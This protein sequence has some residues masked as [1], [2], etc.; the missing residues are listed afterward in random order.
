MVTP[1]SS[2]LVGSL[3][4]AADEEALGDGGGGGAPGRLPVAPIPTALQNLSLNNVSIWHSPKITTNLLLTPRHRHLPP[5]SMRD[6][7]PKSS[8]A[9]PC[10]RD[11]ASPFSSFVV[12]IPKPLPWVPLG[13]LDVSPPT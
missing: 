9:A 12:P 8:A 13:V 7:L 2:R 6:P 5:G 11:L 10:A 4:D 1:V 3:V